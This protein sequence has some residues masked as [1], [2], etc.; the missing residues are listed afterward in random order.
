[1][2]HT[3]LAD[4]ILYTLAPHRGLHAQKILEEVRTW[5][6]W[7]VFLRGAKDSGLCLSPRKAY[8]VLTSKITYIIALGESETMI[9]PLL[10]ITCT[11]FTTPPGLCV[12]ENV[13]FFFELV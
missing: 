1:M 12:Q 13:T 8:A 7:S 11:N 6:S 2:K 3:T 9:P 10:V 5:R 4:L